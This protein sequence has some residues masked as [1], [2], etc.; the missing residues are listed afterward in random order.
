MLSIGIHNRRLRLVIAWITLAALLSL[1]AFP[2][3]HALGGNCSPMVPACE[4]M[5]CQDISADSSG[6]HL[7]EC[8]CDDTDQECDCACCV[9]AA[10]SLPHQATASPPIPLRIACIRCTS[11]RAPSRMEPPPLP[12]PKQTHHSHHFGVSSTSVQSIQTNHSNL[13]IY[14]NTVPH[15]RGHRRPHQSTSRRVEQKLLRSGTLL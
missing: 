6:S 10:L 5:C 1:F 4:L 3:S 9:Y 14:E 7:P 15:P 2:W 13:P 12:P 8:P 11:Q